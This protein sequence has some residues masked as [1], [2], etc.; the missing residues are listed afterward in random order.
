MTSPNASGDA[1]VMHT[2]LKTVPILGAGNI[3]PGV[4]FTWET[5]CKQYF[6]HKGVDAEKQV[7]FV[8]GGFQDPRLVDWYLTNS[9]EL[10]CLKFPDFMDSLREHW[11]PHNWH[12][13]IVSDMFATRQKDDQSLDAYITI[14]E[15]LNVYLR[16]RPEKL[17][18]ASL[19]S[20]ISANAC[21]EIRALISRREYSFLT[22]VVE[23]STQGSPL[24]TLSSR[25]SAKSFAVQKKV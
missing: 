3:T 8:S 19:K 22:Y 23:A 15:K 12:A 18:D 24:S 2:N 4:L 13:D 11:L 5:G 9:A 14:I 16:G 25:G 20:L 7:A 17:D 21:K 1:V 10:E 6:R